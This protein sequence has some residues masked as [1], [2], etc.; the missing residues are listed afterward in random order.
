MKKNMNIMHCLEWIVNDGTKMIWRRSRDISNMVKPK[1]FV[2]TISPYSSIS[3]GASHGM[4]E[5]THQIFETPASSIKMNANSISVCTSFVDT[6]P[7]E[8]KIGE[9][10]NS[11]V[12][13]FEII[14]KQCSASPSLMRKVISWVNIKL[15][16]RKQTKEDLCKLSAGR[17]WVSTSFHLEAQEV[18][19]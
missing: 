11:E 12:E 19:T 8:N 14:K 17:V 10:Y 15:S 13:L 16:T 5:S 2:R 6:V 4:E 18:E 1:S 9:V 7:H 3:S